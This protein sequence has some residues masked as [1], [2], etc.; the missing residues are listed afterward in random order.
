MKVIMRSPLIDSDFVCFIARHEVMDAK[1]KLLSN[2][3]L[4]LV[5]KILT[6]NTLIQSWLVFGFC[7]NRL[8]KVIE[9]YV[10]IDV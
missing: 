9:S 4:F 5:S 3:D 10:L 6:Q 2:I 1:N 8:D 7:N